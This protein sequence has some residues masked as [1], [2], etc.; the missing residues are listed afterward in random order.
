MNINDTVPVVAILEKIVCSR[1]DLVKGWR[2]NNLRQV[3]M[4]G[5]TYHEMSTRIIYYFQLSLLFP[6]SWVWVDHP[7]PL[8]QSTA[9][10][11]IYCHRPRPVLENDTKLKGP[12]ILAHPKPAQLSRGTA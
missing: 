2:S 4:L 12:Y 5:I 10:F 3:P 6:R 11:S 8:S 1:T 7:G 9:T